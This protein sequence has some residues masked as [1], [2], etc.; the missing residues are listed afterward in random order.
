MEQKLGNNKVVLQRFVR[1]ALSKFADHKIEQ[2][3]AAFFHDKDKSGFDRGLVI[4]S[5]TIRSN[6][7]YKERE[8]KSMLEWLQKHGYASW[9]GESHVL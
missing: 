5:D 6:A 7:N 1:L 4:V 8:E 3:I 9:V 2:D